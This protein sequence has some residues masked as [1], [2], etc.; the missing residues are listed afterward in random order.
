MYP[1]PILY[2]CISVI[3]NTDP[4]R[5]FQE[6]YLPYPLS[7]YLDY[8][9]VRGQGINVDAGLGDEDDLVDG[10]PEKSEDRGRLG[11]GLL[12]VLYRIQ[13]TAENKPKV[14]FARQLN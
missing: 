12:A 3:V 13:L 10:G 14:L 8:L 6:D 7:I 1:D 5:T 2:K 4:L 9:L 11:P